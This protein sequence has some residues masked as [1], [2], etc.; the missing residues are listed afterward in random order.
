M[1]CGMREEIA[2][3]GSSGRT[4]IVRYFGSETTRPSM[5][6]LVDN[7][8]GVSLHRSSMAQFSA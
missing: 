1:E 6:M 2:V 5:L 7:V 3:T 4:G 8:M